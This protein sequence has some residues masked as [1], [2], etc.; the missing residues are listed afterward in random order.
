MN[1]SLCLLYKF[2]CLYPILNGNTNLS[3]LQVV[4]V[5]ARDVSNAKAFA[6]RFG[7]HKAYGSYAELAQDKDV[8]MTLWH[9]M[10][11]HQM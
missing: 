10:S 3:I 2:P 6:E 5:A 4:A 11:Y 1:H 8:G 9:F 7:I